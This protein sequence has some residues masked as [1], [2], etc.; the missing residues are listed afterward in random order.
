MSAGMSK[1][2]GVPPL[3]AIMNGR[4]PAILRRRQVDPEAAAA[5]FCRQANRIAAVTAGD[6][7]HQGEAEPAAA[8]GLAAPAEA[9]ER[10][11]DALALG[12]RHAG[13]V[14]ATSS[15]ARPASALTEIAIGPSP[16]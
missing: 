1:S 6:V 15:T 9:I 10:L 16:A 7:A 12:G 4:S 8:A 5:A 13:P 2:M 11:E 14:V 3:N